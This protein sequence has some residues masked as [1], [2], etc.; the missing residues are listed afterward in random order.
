MKI[1]TGTGAG[2]RLGF[3]VVPSSHRP[4]VPSSWIPEGKGFRCQINE[5]DDTESFH[6][7]PQ[8]N[9]PSMPCTPHTAHRSPLSALHSFPSSVA[10]HRCR[11]KNKENPNDNSIFRVSPNVVQLTNSSVICNGVVCNVFNHHNHHHN[12]HHKHLRRCTTP[13]PLSPTASEG[14]L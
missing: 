8:I 7:F 12:H 6:H 9:H 3:P 10:C 5:H 2:R 13:S 11:R 4:I 14:P 1:S